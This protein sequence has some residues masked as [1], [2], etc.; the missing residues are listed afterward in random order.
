MDHRDPEPPIVVICFLWIAARLRQRPMLSVTASRRGRRV[1]YKAPMK[2]AYGKRAFD[3]TI[4]SIGLVVGSP[5][6]LATAVAVWFGF[7]FPILFRQARPGLGGKPFYLYKFRTMTDARDARGNLRPDAQR[8]TR[9]GVV[10]RRFSL[11]ELPQLWN[12]L[13]GDMSLVGPRPLLMAYLDRYTPE[14]ARRHEVKPG[15]TGWSQI[16]GRNVIAWDQKLALDVWY[17]RNRSFGLD[18]KILAL[19]AIKVLGARGIAAA[20][21]ATMPEFLGASDLPK[22]SDETTTTRSRS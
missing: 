1:A 7:G 3:L 10:L 11:D 5:L 19:T 21:H 4:A 8:L 2:N 14:Q 17:V 12:V 16:N 22:N 20:G 18:L 13:R 15:V 9:L 6:W